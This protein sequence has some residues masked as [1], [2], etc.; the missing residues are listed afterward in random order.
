MDWYD[1]LGLKCLLCLHAQVHHVLPSSIAAG[2]EKKMKQG[3][4]I[5]SKSTTQLANGCFAMKPG[6]SQSPDGKRSLAET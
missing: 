2:M 5:K 3:G 4:S 1:H 6:D